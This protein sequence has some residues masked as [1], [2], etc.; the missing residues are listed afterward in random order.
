MLSS[1]VIPSVPAVI[2]KLKHLK[3]IS[4]RMIPA[5]PA[6]IT[7]L[8]QFVFVVQKIFYNIFNTVFNFYDYVWTFSPANI[9]N[10]RISEILK[11][12]KS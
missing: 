10:N 5:L 12:L 8:N 3:M 4:S 1:K 9:K 7:Q 2:T 6:V 11:E